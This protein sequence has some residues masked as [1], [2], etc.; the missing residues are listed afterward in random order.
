MS[1]FL[2]KNWLSLFNPLD[3]NMR[4]FPRISQNSLKIPSHFWADIQIQ[5][6]T[7]A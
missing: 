7:Y 6:F 4:Y 5:S 3:P 1:I 2:G